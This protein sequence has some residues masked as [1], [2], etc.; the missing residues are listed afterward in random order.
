MPDVICYG[1]RAIPIGPD[2]ITFDEMAAAADE[3]DAT[4]VVARNHVAGR[5]RRSADTNAG[6]VE[7]ADSRTDVSSVQGARGVGAEEV[8]RD[9]DA[10]GRS[11]KNLDAVADEAI[12]DQTA[13]R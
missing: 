6:R 7:D 5:R 13:A 11:P 1:R 4:G 10:G 9:D 12:D 3:T 2:Q 8:A